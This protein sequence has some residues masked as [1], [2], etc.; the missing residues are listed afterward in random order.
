LQHALGQ[1]FAGSSIPDTLISIQR[2]GNDFITV[3]RDHI[4]K[5]DNILFGIADMHLDTS[6]NA[7]ILARFEQIAAGRG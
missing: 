3:L 6:Q 1:Y 2:D 5:E 7:A 4:F